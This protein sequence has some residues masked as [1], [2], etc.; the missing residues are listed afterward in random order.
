MKLLLILLFLFKFILIE[1][2]ILNNKKIEFFKQSQKKEPFT[3]KNTSENFNILND[4]GIYIKFQNN[5]WIYFSAD[6]TEVQKLVNNYNVPIGFELSNPMALA[7]SAIVR[8]K[9]NLVHDGISLDTNYTAK[10]VIIGIVDQGLDYNHPD[11]KNP[12]GSTRV[13]RYWDHTISSP[14]IYDY[15]GYGVLWDS[16]SINNL[17]CTSNEIGSAHGTSVAGIASGNGTANGKNK[18]AAPEADIIVVETDFNM[19]NWTLSIAD[20]CDYIFKV[21][22]SLGKPAVVNLSLGTY[23]GSHD[24]QDP[25]ALMI[26]DLLDEQSGRI[27]VCAAGNSGNELPF[28]VHNE[29]D[30]D[31]SFFWNI[32]NPGNTYVGNNKILID[33]WTDTIEANYQFSY[34]ADR[35][36][37]NYGFVG[38]TPSRNAMDNT[39]NEV[40]NDTLYNSNGDRIATIQTWRNIEGN[41]LHMQTIFWTIDSLDYLYRFEAYGT[42][43]FDAWGGA[44]QLLSDFETN[45]PNDSVMPEI[46][47][48]RMPDTLQS[49]VTSWACSEKVITVGNILNRNSY[50]DNNGNP[51]N[52][53]TNTSIG[54]ISINSSKGP[55]R[56]GI[57]K[58]DLCASGDWSFGSG[59]F[60]YLNNPANY[61]AI[62]QG[63]YHVKNGGTSMASPVVAG[64][65]ALFLQKCKNATY[66]DFKSAIQNT[67]TADIHTGVTPNFAYGYGKLDALEL[68]LQ[69]H[70]PVTIQGPNGIC[71]GELISLSYNTNM[72]PTEIAWNNGSS[73]SS[74]TISQPGIYYVTLT[75]DVGCKSRSDQ[76]IISSYALPIVEAG[77]NR[78]ECPFEEITLTASG[79]ATQY[80]WND[81][82]LNNVPF[83]P[84][85]IG[86]YV[87]TG[88]NTNGCIAEDSCFID[89]YSLMEVEYIENN[90][91]VGLNSI[92]FNLTDGIPSGGIYTGNGVIGTS[93]HPGLANVG[94]HEIIY[95]YENNNGCFSRDTSFIE[96]YEDA[97]LNEV[98]NNLAIYPNPNTG[99]FYLD[100][101]INSSIEIYNSE[102]KIVYRNRIY[103]DI[104]LKIFISSPGIYH[105][106]YI[107]EEFIANKKIIVTN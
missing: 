84:E 61:P 47:N 77:P 32:N 72:T 65:A 30:S 24:A 66:A 8:H 20:A 70:D 31:T 95:A 12:D 22:D 52:L 34:G 102:G 101:K 53:V 74:I 88:T 87:V 51:Q 54:E 29:V 15:Y 107:N 99:I 33:F 82:I 37:P 104:G 41:R 69:N 11:F 60:W 27:V 58:P 100:G 86:Y 92:A 81:N 5:H 73:N 44:W 18:G 25:A 39:N 57:Q 36:S 9:I 68:I 97:A 96:V 71:V 89:F 64:T 40:V 59:P 14:S 62:E 45:I 105:L 46:V 78:I 56:K 35:P 42:G 98:E 2:Q 21:A 19:A 50:I 85:S 38:R 80:V 91:L 93:F 6:Y 3:I 17:T 76:K 7:D 48:Y 1:G 49:M 10:D 13:L 23:L 28:H 75:D 106:K 83:V 94:I 26:D 55:S 90:T 79:T 63:G 103:N 67:A 4:L 16:T 43:S